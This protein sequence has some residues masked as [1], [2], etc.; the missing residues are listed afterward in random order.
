MTFRYALKLPATGGNKLA[1]FTSWAAE[2]VP[3]LDYSLPPQVPIKTDCLTVRVR[4]MDD[5]VR[6]RDACPTRLP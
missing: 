3:G 5:L 2:H 6:L 1:R 4:S